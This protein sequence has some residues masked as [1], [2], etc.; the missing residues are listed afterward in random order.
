[1]PFLTKFPHRLNSDGT[2]DSICRSCFRTI[3][4][5]YQ[6]AD[7]EKAEN[8]HMCSPVDLADIYGMF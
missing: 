8:A 6:E 5:A 7:L 4:T 3:A 2:F 1:M